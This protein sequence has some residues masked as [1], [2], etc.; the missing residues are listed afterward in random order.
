MRLIVLFRPFGRTIS[1]SKVTLA[2]LLV[3]VVSASR[4]DPTPMQGVFQHRLHRHALERSVQLPAGARLVQ[5][6]AY[7]PDPAQVFDVYIPREAHN[8]PVIFMVHGGGW[9][10]GSMSAY[11]VV[12]NKIDYFLPKG[13]IFISI[14]YRKLPQPGITVMTEAED[15]ARALAFAQQHAKEWSGSPSRFVLMGHSAGAHLVALISS[16][17]R[18]WQSADAEPWLGTVALDSAAYNVVEVMNRRHPRLYDRAFGDDPSFWKEV[19]PT[20]RLKGAPPPMVLV[21]SSLRRHSC[22][23]ANAYASKAN[24]LGG[25]VKVVPVALTHRRINVELGVAQPYTQKVGDFIYSLES[26]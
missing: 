10:R 21:C 9:Q 4:A 3:I 22:T 18:I 6:V 16:V 25:H 17:P 1:I 26:N 11:G 15:V 19:S 7:G 23:A 5:N 2:V 20:L 12:Q 24:S 8:A 14:E 13:Y